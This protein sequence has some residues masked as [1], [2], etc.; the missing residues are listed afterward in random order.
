[1]TGYLSGKNGLFLLII[2]TF[3]TIKPLFIQGFFP[4]HDDTQPARVYEM[5]SALRDGMFPV[6]WSE[7]LGYG[8]GYPLFNFYAPL[9]YYIGSLFYFSGFDALNATK[10]MIGLAMASSAVAMYYLAKS[11]WGVPGAVLSGLLY[12][13]APYHALNLY[14]RGDVAELYAYTFIPLAFLGLHQIFRTLSDNNKPVNHK[15]I[16]HLPQ[17]GYS[18]KTKKQIKQLNLWI[19]ITQSAL[20]FAAIIV[21]HNLTALMTTPFLLAAIFIYTLLLIRKKLG[22][23]TGYLFLAAILGIGLSAFYWL[24]ALGEMQYT[25]VLSQVGG[26]ADFRLHFVCF[27]QIWDSPW[28]FG[29][30]APGCLDGMSF[31]LGK[32]HIL[33]SIAVLAIVVIQRKKIKQLLPV[34]LSIFIFLAFSIFLTT[35]YSRFLWELVPVMKFIQYPWRFLMLSAFFSSLLA[36]FMMTYLDREVS[37]HKLPVFTSVF[38]FILLMV[39]TLFLYLKLFNPQTVMSKTASDYTSEIALKWKISAISDEYMPKYFSKPQDKK[40]IVKSKF[41]VVQGQAEINDIE[42]KAQKMAA[43]VEVASQPTL[44]LIKTAYFPSWNLYLNNKQHKYDITKQGLITAL[45]P[46]NHSLLL[47]IEQTP[48]EK[49]ANLLSIIGIFILILGIIRALWFSTSR[50]ALSMP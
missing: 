28:G 25:N 7:N 11:F 34:I 46:G 37:R 31:R 14:V 48:L 44:V 30:S 3:F 50:S 1:M 4:M 23:E 24:P 49:S 33:L 20:A 38:S 13:Y 35:A 22:K 12:A 5:A 19:W 36:G 6:R 45:P 8:Y 47:R 18:G 26:K 41:S 29:G 27:E 39:L 16:N 21:S 43:K 42:V 15:N 40:D 10:M 9:A 2:L 17:D 32:L